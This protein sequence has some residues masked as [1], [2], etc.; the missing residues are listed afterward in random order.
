M[1]IAWGDGQ[2]TEEEMSTH[3]GVAT[4][5]GEVQLPSVTSQ[6]EDLKKMLKKRANVKDLKG[7]SSMLKYLGICL[8]V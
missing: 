7:E 6:R 4:G 8:P 1:E 5:R 3:T 2:R